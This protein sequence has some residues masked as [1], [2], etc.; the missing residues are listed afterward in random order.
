M[1]EYFDDGRVKRV[2][3]YG[4]TCDIDIDYDN[5]DL[6]KIE[7]IMLNDFSRKLM[8]I[9]NEHMYAMPNAL[10]MYGILER[11]YYE[12]IHMSITK[13]VKREV[14]K[15][16]DTDYIANY[17]FEYFNK[18]YIGPSDM[19]PKSADE[20]RKWF[21]AGEFPFMHTTLFRNMD[22]RVSMGYIIYR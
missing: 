22:G 19:K 17:V 6:K 13:E 14:I 7:T 10:F 4:I 18:F 3:G 15:L 5:P 12:D 21:S 8:A 20:I 2:K 1:I 9:H 11:R 16:T